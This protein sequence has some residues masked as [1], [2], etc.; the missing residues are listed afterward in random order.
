MA[1][2]AKNLQEEEQIYLNSSQNQKIASG[3][4]L[5]VPD[6]SANLL[7]RAFPNNQNFYYNQA[8]WPTAP[9]LPGSVANAV[10]DVEN[11][12]QINAM[13]LAFGTANVYGNAYTLLPGQTVSFGNPPPYQVSSAILDNPFTPANSSLLAYQNQQT[14]G[15]YGVNWALGSSQGGSFPSAHTMASTIDALTY[16]ILAPGY[17][18][19]L[20]LGAADFAYDLNVNGVHYPLD[21]I[22]GRILGTYLV[23]ET[24]AGEPLY[25]ATTFTQTNLPSLSQAMQTYL[26]GGGS[27]PFAA[28]CASGVAA[29]IAN[30]VIPTAAQY[31]LAS[32]NYIKFLTYDL[33]PVGPTNLAP[34]V[35]T[36]AHVLIATRF[37]YLDVSQLNQILATT[38]LPSGGPI[39]NN[40]GWAR[41]NLYAASSGYGAFPTDVTVNMNAALGGLNAF[42]V[43]SNN[44][45]GPGG[46]TLR[47]SGT[48]VLAGDDTYTGDTTVQGGTL[49]VTGALAGNLAIWSGAAC[50]PATASSAVR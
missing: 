10:N 43:W 46:L 34:L 29:C 8:G 9:A 19:Q 27:L 15:L 5:V 42:D 31:S 16:A 21:V 6:I 41:L 20:T 39:D 2:L 47:G 13:K 4:I 33:P 45:S 12:S 30:S 23:A 25:P 37:P 17:Y 28:T 11:N 48:L 22:A 3:T 38:E 18:Q 24:L 7:I 1:V 26:G 44:I 49:A 14:P 40:T 50:S 32:Q 36:D 35:P